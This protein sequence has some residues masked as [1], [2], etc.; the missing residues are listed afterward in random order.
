VIGDLVFSAAN[1]MLDGIEAMLNGA[2]R[3]ID[4]VHGRIRDALAAV[5]IETTFGEDR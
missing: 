5:G 4:A 1:R 2:I 3:R